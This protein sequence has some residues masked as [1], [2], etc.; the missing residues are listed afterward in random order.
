MM[1]PDGWQREVTEEPTK[2][3]LQK[4]QG[5][6]IGE[7]TFRPQ[8]T[9]VICRATWLP[10]VEDAGNDFPLFG[11]DVRIHDAVLP[12]N[13]IKVSMSQELCKHSVRGSVHLINRQVWKCV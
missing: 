3:N 6:G 1:A 7:T 2:N 10:S 11:K 4:E 9:L 8:D 13:F 5:G 12:Q